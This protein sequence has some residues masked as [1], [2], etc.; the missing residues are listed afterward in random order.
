[1]CELMNLKYL[2]NFGISWRIILIYINAKLEYY[3][4]TK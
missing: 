1:M 3:F 4:V 2:Q